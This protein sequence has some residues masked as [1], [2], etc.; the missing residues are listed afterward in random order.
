MDPTL[1]SELAT[2]VLKSHTYRRPGEEAGEAIR[3]DKQADVII[4]E[5]PEEVGV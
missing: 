2:H 4:S 5:A 1:D 3:I